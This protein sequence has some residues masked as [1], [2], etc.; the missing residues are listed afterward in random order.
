M[1]N[2]KEA[3]RFFEGDI[4]ATRQTGIEIVDARPG[5]AKCSLTIDER[6]KNATGSVMGG[7]MFTM[8]DYAFAVA[9]NLEHTPTVTQSSQITYLSPVRGKV[10]YAET[11]K[12]RS[13]RKTCF[14][15]ILISDDTGEDIAYVTV[16][17]FVI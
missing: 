5:Y 9:A 3:I 13:G 2:L 6:H 16:S 11:E 12:I 4:Y 1:D 14:Y 17:G 15:K 8:A 10:L 7:V